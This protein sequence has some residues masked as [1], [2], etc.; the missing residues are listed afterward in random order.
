MREGQFILCG[1]FG[2][3]SG[4]MADLPTMAEIAERAR[5]EDPKLYKEMLRRGW[6]SGAAPSGPMNLK[7]F[8]EAEDHQ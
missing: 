4:N 2:S 3:I 1:G 7:S 5:M 8:D 6:I